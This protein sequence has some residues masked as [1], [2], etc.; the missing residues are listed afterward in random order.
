M[1]KTITDE[2]IEQMQEAIAVLES[3]SQAAIDVVEERRRQ[4]VVEDFR[5]DEDDHYTCGELAWA[6]TCYLQNAAVA[7]K[8][9]GLG[10]LD[11]GQCVER[12]TSLPKPKIW[13]WDAEWWK[14]AGQRRDLIKAAALIIAEIERLDRAELAKPQGAAA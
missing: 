14:P 9:Q 4:V 10:L 5:T 11:V 12:G 3:L 2:Q 6:A 8:M 13:P 1:I 7:A